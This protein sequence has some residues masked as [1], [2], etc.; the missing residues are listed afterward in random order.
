[1][2]ELRV[3]GCGSEE[4]LL[5]GLSDVE[6]RHQQGGLLGKSTLEST[7]VDSAPC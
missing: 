7:A 4:A 6:E 3:D 5:D 1:M 2:R